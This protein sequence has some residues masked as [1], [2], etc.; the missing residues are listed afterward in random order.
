M[1]RLKE[2]MTNN[3]KRHLLIAEDNADTQRLLAYLLKS[4]FELSVVAGVDEALEAARQ[5]TFDLFL[6]D[7]NLGEER[8]GV[9]LLESLQSLPNQGNVPA[10]ALTAYALPGDRERFLESGFDGY[11]SKPFTRDELT[12][13]IESILKAHE[14]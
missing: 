8:T 11:I 6:L 4:K 9:N 13:Q 10:V 7:I 1:T 5:E 2:G 3:S 12:G 14:G